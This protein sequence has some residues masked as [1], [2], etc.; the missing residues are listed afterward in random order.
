MYHQ[1]WQPNILELSIHPSSPQG[2]RREMTSKTV[3]WSLLTDNSVGCMN[4]C[5]AS[6]HVHTHTHT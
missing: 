1:P 3:L 5:G 4:V 2:E 6:T